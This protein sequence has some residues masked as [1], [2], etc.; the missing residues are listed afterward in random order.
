MFSLFLQEMCSIVINIII[1]KKSFELKDS[2]EGYED[3]SLIISILS[4]F[5]GIISLI[6][7]TILGIHSLYF[8]VLSRML[9]FIFY[10]LI[11]IFYLIAIMITTYVFEMSKEN[12]DSEEIK[13]FLKLKKI[14]IF[15]CIVKCIFYLVSSV[16]TWI[17]R[18]KIMKEINDSPFNIVDE[19]FTEQMYK[20]IIDHSLNP[21]NKNAKEE[22]NRYTLY[23]KEKGK[24]KS[25]KSLPFSINSSENG[26]KIESEADKKSK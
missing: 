4:L 17:E 19:E 16:V 3:E 20:N 24:H 23:S 22:F 21:L 14:M 26:S 5:Q 18:K 12:N 10:S 8:K 9:W 7:I 13:N 6:S 1:L 11:M 2:S 15:L 25:L